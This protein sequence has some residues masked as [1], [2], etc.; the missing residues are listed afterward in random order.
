[1]VGLGESSLLLRCSYPHWAFSEGIHGGHDGINNSL[2]SEC[3]AVGQVLGIYRDEEVTTPAL[4]G[5]TS[6][7][8]TDK[9][10]SAV[11][12]CTEQ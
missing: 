5:L 10:S 8:E 9:N 11:L 4:E 12:W 1:M 6:W 2:E 3:Q 7:W